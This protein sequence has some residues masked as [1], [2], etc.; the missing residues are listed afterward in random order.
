MNFTGG[1]NLFYMLYD[2]QLVLTGK[3]NDVG[4]PIMV[5]VDDSYRAGIE[6]MWDVKIATRL[7][8]DATATFSRSRIKDF[9]EFVDDWDNGGQ[10]AFELGSTDLSFS[11]R[12]LANS[13]L[14]WMPY[15]KGSISLVSNYTGKQYIDNTASD[16]RSL[17]PWF[18]NNLLADYT[19]ETRF[20]GD[21][22][23]RLMVNNL[24]DASYESNAW[25]Y[26]YIL[27]G[28]RYEMDGYFPQAGRHIMLGLD[29]RF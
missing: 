21:V 5:N 28:E 18:V 26:S 22:T 12:F 9:T 2:Q 6:L 7:R 13:Q 16:D 27:G 11:P 15:E 19:F 1:V 3:I 8:W 10:Q 14:K 24:L 25:V 29:L 23:L 17:D 20:A 4:A